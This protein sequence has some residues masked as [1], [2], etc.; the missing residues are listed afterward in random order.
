MTPKMASMLEVEGPRDI[1]AAADE[2]QADEKAKSRMGLDLDR[3]SHCSEKNHLQPGSGDPLFKR[4]VGAS[5]GHGAM[6]SEK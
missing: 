2:A 1:E 3:G 6:M 4:Q 5:S